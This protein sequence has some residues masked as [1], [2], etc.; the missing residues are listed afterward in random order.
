VPLKMDMRAAEA[1]VRRAAS[2]TRAMSPEWEAKVERLSRLC[3]DGISKTH[4]AF[5]GTSMLAKA[6]DSRTDLRAIKPTLDKGNP[7]AYSARSLCH[8]VLVPLSAELAFS[9]GVSGRE[10]L[11]NQPYF[12]MNRLGDSAPVHPGGRAAFDFMVGLVDELQQLGS[13]DAYKALSAF[14]TVRRRYQRVYAV[15][16]AAILSAQRN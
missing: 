5:L 13:L 9:L 7:Y 15:S 4:I 10:P 16:G 3:E 1:L 2:N 12:R 11:N 6:L 14:I 8:T